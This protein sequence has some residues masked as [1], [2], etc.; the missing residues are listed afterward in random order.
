MRLLPHRT[1]CAEG[2]PVRKQFGD[3][4]LVISFDRTYFLSVTVSLQ[5]AL[6]CGSTAFG[7]TIAVSMDD[8]D[9]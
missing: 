5:N 9:M 2:T 4:A 3:V 8:T 7:A 1:E 6:K